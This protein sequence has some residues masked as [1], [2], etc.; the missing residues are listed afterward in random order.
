[1]NNDIGGAISIVIG[2]TIFGLL[3]MIVILLPLA[4]IAAVPLAIVVV[5][6]LKAY[7]SPG[8]GADP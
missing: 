2:L 1:L 5:I 7:N 8:E 6:G 4:A 3:L